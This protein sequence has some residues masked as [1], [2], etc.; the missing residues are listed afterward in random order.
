MRSWELQQAVFTRLGAFAA[1]TALVGARI[2]DHAPQ[3]V[4]FPYIVVGDTT[5][6]EFDTDTS[7]GADHTVTVHA[8]SRYRGRKEVKQIQRAIY[9]A[10]HRHDLAVTG[11]QTV[12]CDWQYAENFVDGDGLTRHGVTR[13]RVLLDE[14][15]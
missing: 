8:W 3:D 14:V 15:I 2:Y 12:T 4:V 5:A 13:F 9:E 1:V 11:A 10:L 7:S 6:N